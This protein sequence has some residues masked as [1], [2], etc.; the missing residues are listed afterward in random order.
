MEQGAEPDGLSFMGNSN[1]ILAGRI[2]YLLNLRG[3]CLTID[4]ACSSSLTAIHLACDALNSGSAD[5]AIAG[6]V[7]VLPTSTFVQAATRA[8]M[9]SRS[10]QCRP[11][12]ADADGFVPGEAAGA[13]VLK[14]LDR[15]KADRDYI[16]GVIEGSGTNQDGRTNG[17][18]A[19]SAV[20]QAD[21]LQQV[22]R[23]ARVEPSSISYVEAH[24]TG[25]RLG[26]PIEVEAL[27]R[28]FRRSTHETGVCALGSV[29]ASVGHTMSAA[30]VVS[31]IKVLLAMKH[32]K[33][34]ASLNMAR[35][36]PACELVT[37]PFTVN[38]EMRH[39][40][41]REGVRRA[42]VSGFGFSGSNAHIVL[43]EAPEAEASASQSGAPR[44]FLI[45]ARSRPLL[46]LF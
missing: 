8:G 19:P 20:A 43:R 2:A 45:S 6:G 26:D 37:S 34:P 21:L 1:A 32:R 14:P 22:Y 17:I 30:G 28:V 42:V 25:T 9:L 44:L 35:P 29:K 23:R 12:D 18:T 3:P 27:T 4:T 24:G 16:W 36:N 39:W 33:I 15:A 10:G 31:M 5:M 11:F 46:L 40:H 38:T 41:A 13:L 7:C